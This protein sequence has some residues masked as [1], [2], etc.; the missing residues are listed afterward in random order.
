VL[1]SLS[2]LEMMITPRSETLFG[3]IVGLSTGFGFGDRKSTPVLIFVWGRQRIYP[4]RL[5]DLNIQEM[6]YNTNL[7]PTRVTV[8]VSLQVIGGKNPFYI[9]TQAQQEILAG[10]NLVQSPELLRAI[11]KVG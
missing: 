11:V 2:T 10:L 1:P 5:T 7:N 4:V 9:F 3:G 6:E 8:G